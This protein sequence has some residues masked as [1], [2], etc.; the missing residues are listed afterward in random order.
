MKVF[1]ENKT[2]SPLQPGEPES[3]S[4]EDV[5][6]PAE[7]FGELRR[8]LERSQ[9][10]LPPTARR[11]KGWDVGV[12][13]RFDLGDLVVRKDTEEEDRGN[14][15]DGEGDGDEEDG[16]DAANHEDAEGKSPDE[17]GNQD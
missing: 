10:V 8:G 16:R 12:L 7:L 2:W 14:E 11:F 1:Y 17:K 5:E 4:I 6:F 15:A 13:Q 9:R 3:A